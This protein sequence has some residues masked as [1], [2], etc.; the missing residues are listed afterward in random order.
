MGIL[1][2]EQFRELCCAMII[3]YGTQGEKLGRILLHPSLY[4]KQFSQS[5]LRSY[6]RTIIKTCNELGLPTIE[7]QLTP[8]PNRYDTTH[9][10][11][12]RKLTNEQ[13]ELARKRLSEKP[14]PTDTSI[15]EEVGC[16]VLTIKNIRLGRERYDPL[17][18]EHFNK[19]GRK[20]LRHVMSDEEIQAV[21]Y[22]IVDGKS[23]IDIAA[24]LHIAA[25]TVD[26]IKRQRGRYAPDYTTKHRYMA[27]TKFS[28]EK[29]QEVRKQLSE[30]N[31]PIA[32][33]SRDLGVSPIF[34]SRVRD[35]VGHLG[36]DGWQTP[37]HRK[38]K[39]NSRLD[40]D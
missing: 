25:A 29:V 12:S 40:R 15:A 27:N 35:N 31:D 34:V 17:R 33:I 9:Y 26:A 7:H 37:E 36:N 28:D 20:Y 1:T 30:T 13:V 21:Q 14:R 8:S 22:Q 18:E 16:C 3:K 19:T 38:K 10:G 32:Q 6:N 2:E 11:K 23:N 24:D 5:V 4:D 39:I